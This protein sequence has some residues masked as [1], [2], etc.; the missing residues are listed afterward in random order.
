MEGKKDCVEEEP[1]T[2]TFDIME[3]ARG[4][5]RRRNGKDRVYNW[6]RRLDR[7]W[8]DELWTEP[9][10]GT[11]WTDG[12]T[13]E[14]LTVTQGLAQTLTKASGPAATQLEEV[15][16]GSRREAEYLLPVSVHTGDTGIENNI[17]TR[18]G[19]G[20]GAGLSDM[21]SEYVLE[22]DEQNA[23]IVVQEAIERIDVTVDKK[24]DKPE[25]EKYES[26]DEKRLNL[27]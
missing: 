26:V 16:G 4:K 21:E 24:E 20:W 13:D 18:P 14:H 10:F 19:G 3:Q 5:K 8:T 6:R 2:T 25:V 7:K 1:T 23:E 12:G 22:K 17:F 27:I 9:V 11:L 15:L